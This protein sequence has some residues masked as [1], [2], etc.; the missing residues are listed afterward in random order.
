M[1]A[2]GWA[3]ALTVLGADAA[4]L[5]AD[6]KELAACVLANGREYVSGAWREMLG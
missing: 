3:T 5:L 2:D 4:I 1:M 6:E